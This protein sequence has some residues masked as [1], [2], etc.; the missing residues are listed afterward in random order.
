[1]LIN[2]YDYGGSAQVLYD[3][4]KER[5]GRDDINISHARMPT[6]DEHQE[7]VRSKPYR[8]WYLIPAPVQALGYTF[9]G[10]VYLT[11]Q[12]EV[13][14]FL[15]KKYQGNGIGKAA[16]EELRRR[17]PGPMKANVNPAN[18]HSARFF[19]GLGFKIK[20]ITYEAP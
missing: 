15:F 17:W 6:F 7:F 2:V 19:T 3:L 14:I 13:G 9:A 10:S 16:I 8:A 20:Q 11:R 18:T 12:R 5:D 4:L 1:M